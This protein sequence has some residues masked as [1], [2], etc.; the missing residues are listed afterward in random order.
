MREGRRPSGVEQPGFPCWHLAFS[1]PVEAR[2]TAAR[3]LEARAEPDWLLLGGEAAASD[4]QLWTAWLALSA[5]NA[6]DRMVANAPDAE[7]LRL[8]AGT[9]QIR[10][11]FETAG[12]SDGDEEAWLVHLPKLAEAGLESDWPVLDVAVLESEAERLASALDA[13]L[14]AARPATDDAGERAA[15][16]RIALA[17][18]G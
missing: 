7:F 16:A 10:V 12:L 3:L 6:H 11:A 8:V 9:H 14:D 13:V 17:D 15:L 2:A 18:L 4:V 5:N 1:S